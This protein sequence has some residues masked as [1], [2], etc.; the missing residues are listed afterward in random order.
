MTLEAT[1]QALAADTALPEEVATTTTEDD[2]LSAAF[3][4]ISAGEAVE[5]EA[6][7]PEPDVEAPEPEA[8][9][10]A[11]AVEAP[12]DVPVALRKHWQAMDP[13]AREAIVT[14]QREMSRKLSDMGREVQ[15]L[16]PIK[17]V[18]VQ[19]AKEMP[20]LANMRPDE[21]AS[22]VFQLA[23][24]SND[25]KTKPLDTFIGLAKQ[26]GMVDALRQAFG[27]NAEGATE[28]AAMQ[29][30]IA[31]L[32][33]QLARAASPD[34]IREQVSAVT[35]EQRIVADVQAFA[36]SQEHWSD[37]E[38][39]LPAFIA[40]AK[41]KMPDAS[42]SD[43]LARAYKL[44]VADLLET[45]PDLKAKAATAVEAVEVPDPERAKGAIQA[46]SVNVSGRVSG[47]TRELS[48]DEILAAA[49]DRATRK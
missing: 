15:G 43:V 9:P 4:R 31:A 18:L 25:F 27:G 39:D 17:S 30:Q 45:R 12:T 13:E 14:S 41:Q 33:D 5:D 20:G 23:K 38:A 26:H 44:A 1:A 2:D 35:N 29:Q 22:Q 11:P 10:E 36:A 21:V 6:E 47:K 24:I 19:A 3:D 40:V 28:T 49:Y 37:V 46:K 32:K 16:S 42:P 8:E 48:E 7:Q 34:F